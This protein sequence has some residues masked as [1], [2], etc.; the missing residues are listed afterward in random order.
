[1]IAKNKN[2]RR[3]SNNDKKSDKN[4]HISVFAIV[5]SMWVHTFLRLR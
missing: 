5:F 3:R 1:M 4:D 2:S